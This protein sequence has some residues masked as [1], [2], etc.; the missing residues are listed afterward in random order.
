MAPQI[1]SKYL[2]RSKALPI[3]VDMTMIGSYPFDNF[4]AARVG[5]EEF[6]TMI[7]P[8]G[9]RIRDLVMVFTEA[10]H[11]VLAFEW[12]EKLLLPSLEFLEFG[13]TNIVPTVT[14]RL[15]SI[16]NILRTLLTNSSRCLCARGFE[17]P[18]A[19]EPGPSISTFLLDLR[20]S[21]CAGLRLVDLAEILSCTPSLETLILY[22]CKFRDRL[23][24]GDN[25]KRNTVVHLPELTKVEMQWLWP[26]VSI[27]SPQSPI[28]TPG[29]KHV[30]AAFKSDYYEDFPQSWL[31][32]LSAANP[33]L[34]SLDVTNCVVSLETWSTALRN[35]HSMF[36]LRTN[37]CEIEDQILQILSPS[38]AARD[39]VLPNLQQLTLDNE[40]KLS[41]STIKAIVCERH[42]NAKVEGAGGNEGQGVA[43][44]ELT[45]RGWDAARVDE[46]DVIAIKGCVKRF[47][48]GVF[49][50]EMSD[51]LDE[52]SESDGQSISG[53]SSNPTTDD[54]ET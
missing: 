11:V 37:S 18:E 27:L 1:T 47:N 22:D 33:Q 41:S 53:Q 29:L 23:P 2:E 34:S 5:L 16:P 35:W 3:S 45:L 21:E 10:E 9:R 36:S 44:Q 50:S 52:G 24:W 32:D 6:F 17:F 46:S 20:I 4:N 15:S 40:L 25:V 39:M 19:W 43:L 26:P 49:N 7:R 54:D 48:L 13:L 38:L 31:T 8:Y 51:V 28:S 12:M 14:N 30:T 42:S